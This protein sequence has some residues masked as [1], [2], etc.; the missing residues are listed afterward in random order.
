MTKVVP[1]VHVIKGIICTFENS[2]ENKV[3][4]VRVLYSKGLLSKEK[5]KSIQLNVSLDVCKTSN[6]RTDFQIY[7][8]LLQEIISGR[9][10]QM[11]SF[12]AVKRSR[13]AASFSTSQ[14]DKLF[15]RRKL[16]TGGVK[17]IN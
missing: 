2:F 10:I 15:I 14:P 8:D 3:R 4:S 12:K 16:W 1:K 13:V 17:F 9:T 5:Y 6:K 11:E 7:K